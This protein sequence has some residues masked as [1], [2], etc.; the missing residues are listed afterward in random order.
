MFSATK[1]IYI[2]ET[3]LLDLGDILTSSSLWHF[4]KRISSEHSPLHFSITSAALLKIH[5]QQN[6]QI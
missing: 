4:N 5:Q 2:Y 6:Q 3:H 1:A